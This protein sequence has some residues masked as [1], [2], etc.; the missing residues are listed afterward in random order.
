MLNVDH[1]RLIAN[2]KPYVTSAERK[3]QRTLKELQSPSR[4]AERD[5]LRLRPRNQ[6]QKPTRHRL[7]TAILQHLGLHRPLLKHCPADN[8]APRFLTTEYWVQ[9][10][11]AYP[12]ICERL[13]I[14]E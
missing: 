9:L 11:C 13:R 1:Y 4:I 8:K 12:L 2:L 14:A 7:R 3:C 6:S 5:P 10:K